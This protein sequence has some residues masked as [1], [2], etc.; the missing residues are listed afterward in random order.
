MAL[1]H[2]IRAQAVSLV[3][4][5]MT[6][7][8]FAAAAAQTLS[9]TIDHQEETNWCWAAVTAGIAHF[10]GAPQWTQCSVA[11]AYLRL[12]C[13]PAGSNPS[14]NTA[15]AL[16]GVLQTTGNLKLTIPN[17]VTFAEIQQE[18]DAGAPVAARIGWFGGGGHFVA[19][20]GYTTA[21]GQ[22][23]DVRDPWYVSSIVSF[24]V[25]TNNYQ[26]AGSWTHT[27]ETQ[28]PAGGGRTHAVRTRGGSR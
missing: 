16:S 18:I 13:C 11:S 19:L 6:F 22:F 8:T 10:W 7:A 15:Q 24:A 28:A 27:Y 14:C 9:L 23:V 3:Q 4:P 12:T 1:P 25:F 20:A 17:A 2:M 5:S 21:N 26:S